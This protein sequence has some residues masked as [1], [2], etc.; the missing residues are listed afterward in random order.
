MKAI[1][2]KC[3]EEYF[4]LLTYMNT[5]L[6]NGYS[7]AKLSM[8]RCLKTGVPIKVKDRV[9]YFFR[10]IRYDYYTKRLP[11]VPST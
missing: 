7:P 9:A 1:L 4:A 6:H 11:I 10:K 3:D 2:N 8:G 5:P